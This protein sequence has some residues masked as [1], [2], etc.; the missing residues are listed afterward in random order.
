[1]IDTIQVAD[2]R[3]VAYA[4]WGDPDGRTV[5]L[6]HGTPGCRLDRPERAKALR[7]VGVRVITYDRPGYGASDRRRGRCVADCA[8]DV[9]QIA[10]AL[11]IGQFAVV[12]S[13][14]G[15]P[16]A[17]AVAACLPD[18]VTRVQCHVGLA[19]YPAEGL[20]WTVGMDPKNVKE[21][22]WALEGEEQ[23]FIELER[24]AAAA[25]ARVAVDPASLLEGFEL[26]EADL[27]VLQDPE[28]QQV[29]LEAMDEMFAHGVSGWVDDDLSLVSPWGFDLGAIA[30]PVEVR[31]GASDVLVPAAHGQWLVV[32]M[33]RAKAVIETGM[34]HLTHPDQMIDH[35]RRA[36]YGTQE[37]R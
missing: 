6:M 17:L 16:H 37:R 10:D 30:L 7:D 35:L 18:R 3:T 23:L 8:G 34:G 1:M 28:V 13:S 36:A 9:Q 20:D 5:F 29:M 24:E 4:Q 12:G 19:P 15:G 21:I 31:F 27:A 32:H 14:G 25:Q 11:G 33:P 2:G 26:P 22:K